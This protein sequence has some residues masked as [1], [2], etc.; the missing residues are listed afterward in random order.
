MEIIGLLIEG[1]DF[2]IFR[3]LK[4]FVNQGYTEC[5]ELQR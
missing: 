2:A 4:Q 5:R 1:I 3:V